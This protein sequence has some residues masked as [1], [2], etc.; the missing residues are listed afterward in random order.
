MRCKFCFATF[1]DV[2]QTI[3]PKGHL[4]ENEALKVVEKIAAAGFEKITFA[5]GEP[6]LCKWLPN[7]IRKAKQLGM[8][9]MIVTNGSKL[10]DAFL[11]QFKSGNELT[12]FLEDLHKRGVEKILEGELDSHLD[13]CY[14]SM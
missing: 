5:G 1:Q 4:P 6:L 3:L 7:L 2:K 8:T 10:T 14:L 11:K 13:Y 12:T 9:T